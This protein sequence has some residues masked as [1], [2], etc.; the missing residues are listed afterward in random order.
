VDWQPIETA[1]KGEDWIIARMNALVCTT[2][3]CDE[4]D[5]WFTFNRLWEHHIEKYGGTPWAPTHWMPL[6]LKP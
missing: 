2:G 4:D 1:P 5:C 3:W 6:K